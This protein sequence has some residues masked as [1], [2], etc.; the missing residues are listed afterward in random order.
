MD[1]ARSVGVVL[2]RAL[3]SALG[4]DGLQSR[5]AG[6][7]GC[8]G[9]DA[10]PACVGVH[11][12][13]ACPGGLRSA[14]SHSPAGHLAEHARREQGGVVKGRQLTQ[15][16]LHIDTRMWVE[17]VCGDFFALPAVVFWTSPTRSRA[18][19][20]SLSL[21]VRGEGRNDVCVCVRLTCVGLALALWL[22]QDRLQ[23]RRPA[24]SVAR[25][26]PAPR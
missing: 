10:S 24:V 18:P 25:L 3:D 8:G 11:S 20:T 1:V 9:G 4:P 22:R 5:L 21:H 19:I 6:G 7:R 23:P 12:R 26:L 2:R 15:K 16:M 17:G 14:V 13:R